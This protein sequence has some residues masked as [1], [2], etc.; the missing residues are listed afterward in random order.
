ML[1]IDNLILQFDTD[2]MRES[3][4]ESKPD[5]LWCKTQHRGLYRYVPSGKLFARVRIGGKLI[6]RSLKTDKVSVGKLRLSDLEKEERQILESRAAVS[7]GKM[8]FG[9]AMGNLTPRLRIVVESL[10]I[11]SGYF[12]NLKNWESLVNG[13]VIT[14]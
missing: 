8:T 6:V 2:G 5:K 3:Q 4:T 12:R 10:E 7:A 11:H 13:I 1:R 14:F 9:D